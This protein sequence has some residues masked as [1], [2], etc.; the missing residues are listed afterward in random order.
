M[1]GPSVTGRSKWKRS[2]HE[3]DRILVMTVTVMM[4]GR[5]QLPATRGDLQPVIIGLEVV[6]KM[7]KGVAG[8]S[9]AGNRPLEVS[10]IRKMVL[11]TAAQ[12]TVT[13]KITISTN[14]G[15]GKVPA[16]I[17]M[18]IVQDMTTTGLKT[19]TGAELI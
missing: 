13:I 3:S 6:V 18:G 15:A 8:G 4:N 10:D 1:I 17:G 19:E 2:W 12:P 14:K 5:A 9:G 11:V 16:K 7:T